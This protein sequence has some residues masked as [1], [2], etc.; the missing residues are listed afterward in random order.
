MRSRKLLCGLMIAALLAPHEAAALAASPQAAQNDRAERERQRNAERAAKQA[1]EQSKDYAE[2]MRDVSDELEELGADLLEERYEDPFLQDYINEM[3][4]SLVPKETPAG[5]LFSFRVL[6]NPEPNAFALP[7]GR[8]YINTG[9]L[10]FVA[11][12]AQLAVVLG[13]EIAHVLERHYVESVRAQKKD[14]LVSTVLGA[15]AGAVIGG[16]FGGK[17]GAVGGAAVGAVSGVVV[18]KVRMNNYNKKQEDEADLLG[19]TLA[20]D[21]HFDPREGVA[22]FKKINDTYGDQSRFANALYGKHSRNQDRMAYIDQLI[23]G[24]LGARYNELRTAGNL[25]T[26]TG[27]MQLYASRMIREVA[28]TLMDTYDQYAVAREHLERIADYRASDPRTLWALGR[29]YKRVGRTEQDRAKA[30]DFFQRAVQL[31]ERNLF[32]Y[33]H[34][35]LGL[36]HAR[37]GATAAAIESLKKY[38]VSYVD[39]YHL[40]PANLES[41][42]DYLLTF[43]DR[44]WTAPAVDPTFLRALY[45]ADVTPPQAASGTRKADEDPSSLIKSSLKPGAKP[46]TKKPETK[47]P[48]TRKPGGME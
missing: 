11:N 2:T 13:H 3:G 47:K 1:A 46:E 17:K 6:N 35:D 10:L 20:L 21:R 29:A 16:I 28:I 9:L 45:P 18:A 7:D 31:D 40:H 15:A 4:Q 25:T 32:P 5:T 23:T 12:E 8:I 44:N 27:Q 42:Y 22:L 30:L 43:G 33:L 14:A 37:L 34:F 19:V 24:N 36:M 39:R 26:G 41:T 38:V 48:E